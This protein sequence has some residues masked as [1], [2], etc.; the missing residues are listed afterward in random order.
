MSFEFIQLLAFWCPCSAIFYWLHCNWMKFIR[1]RVQRR[2]KRSGRTHC[3]HNKRDGGRVIRP[4]ATYSG[5]SL[6]IQAE[7]VV[8]C[9]SFLG[10]NETDD[11][12]FSC[13][14]LQVVRMLR[15]RR[16]GNAGR[17]GG[18]RCDFSA[19]FARCE[20]NSSSFM[21]A[22]K[23]THRGT[24]DSRFEGR[25][26]LHFPP[27]PVRIVARH[28]GVMTASGCGFWTRRPSARGG[29]RRRR[30]RRCAGP[31]QRHQIGIANLPAE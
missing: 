31:R 25:V 12:G 3:Q 20:R 4:D 18:A 26:H 24:Q 6:F 21:C 30:R 9:K 13:C 10:G 28:Q 22:D 23:S 8:L 5:F 17:F 16:A 11:A 2:G 15:K 29:T 1:R 19:P 14:S 7:K 27:P